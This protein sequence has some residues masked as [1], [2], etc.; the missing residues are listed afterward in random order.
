M[1]RPLGP[2]TSWVRMN[3][4][5]CR[6]ARPSTRS[7]SR[8]A[9]D[10]SRPQVLVAAL[11]SSGSI[12]QCGK[13]PP[14]R[15][16]RAGGVQAPARRSERARH[17]RL[18]AVIRGHGTG[19]TASRSAPPSRTPPPAVHC[20]PLP[21]STAG[22]V[23]RRILRSRRTATGLRRTRSRAAASLETERG[24]APHLPQAGD[25]RAERRCRLR[26]TPGMLGVLVERQRARADEAHVAAQDVPQLRQL[27]EAAA[28]A[29]GARAG[30]RAGRRV[31]EQPLGSRLAPTSCG[32]SSPRPS[33]I[34]RNL[35]SANCGPPR[36]TRRW[37]KNTGPG[38][39]DWIASAIGSSSG[40]SAPGRAGAPTRS[41]AR[42]AIASGRR[43][44]PRTGLRDPRSAAGSP[45]QRAPR[46]AAA[47]RR[48]CRADRHAPPAFSERS[49]A[50]VT[51][52]T[53]RASADCAWSG[54]PS[55]TARTKSRQLGGERLV[56]L[57]LGET[58]SPVR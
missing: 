15:A 41:I 31:E 21:V 9:P 45:R 54:S 48:R 47:A 37:R 56:G 33:T 39:V 36:P 3:A 2:S 43:A 16:G 35:R 25:A 19:R 58:M 30:S 7:G 29:G 27:V 23:R 1:S 52:T 18:D 44:R 8:P 10:A 28:A 12:G 4:K 20:A 46:P 40:A 17:E 32:R 53:S 50:S 14:A 51:R 49:A 57:E 5:R 6:A 22:T 24:P 34:V 38:D 26:P 55:R 11:T 13:R 42:L